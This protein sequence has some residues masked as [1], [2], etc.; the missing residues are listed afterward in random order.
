MSIV[1]FFAWSRN[2]DRPPGLR[3]FETAL[4]SG[5]RPADGSSNLACSC[6][7]T[8]SIESGIWWL[9][10]DYGIREWKRIDGRSVGCG[11][12][13]DGGRNALWALEDRHLDRR[14]FE[15]DPDLAL[16]FW[17]RIISSLRGLTLRR[18]SC[19]AVIL[20]QSQMLSCNVCSCQIRFIAYAEDSR[21]E[22]EI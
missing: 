16:I 2:S 3:V 7:S 6:S 9:E 13:G 4:E 20:R 10:K 17:P 5:G 22:K 15:P 21:R 8:S 14:P 19:L 1:F 11:V 12:S 18:P